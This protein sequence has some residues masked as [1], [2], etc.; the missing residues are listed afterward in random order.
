MA[1][2]YPIGSILIVKP[3]DD[4]DPE[5]N[6]MEGQRCRLLQYRDIP[7]GGQLAMVQFST[8][9]RGIAFRLEDL[10]LAMKQ[11]EL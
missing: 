1:E 11:E 9:G 8:Q 5:A 2:R 7:V 4:H 10:Q 6:R 3:S